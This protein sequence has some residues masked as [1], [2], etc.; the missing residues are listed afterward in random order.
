ME[1]EGCPRALCPVVNRP[2]LSAVSR[3]RW[4]LP[5]ST[6]KANRPYY[7]PVANEPCV[8]MRSATRLPDRSRAAAP[9]NRDSRNAAI[10]VARDRRSSAADGLAAVNKCSDRQRSA[11][12]DCARSR[13][14]RRRRVNGVFVRSR[15]QG[16]RN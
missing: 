9:L 15:R 10:G 3:G 1:A 14:R 8:F 4:L 2:M 6:I 16:T 11:R 7:P 5:P 13:R 12:R